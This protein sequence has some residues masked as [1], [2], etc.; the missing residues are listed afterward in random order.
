MG[1]HSIDPELLL[2]T[3]YLWD[4]ILFSGRDAFLFTSFVSHVLLNVRCLSVT[5]WLIETGTERN[6]IKHLNNFLG[7]FGG[8][9]LKRPGCLWSWK[10]YRHAANAYF[11]SLNLSNW[12]AFY[13][14]ETSESKP[15]DIAMGLQFDCTGVQNPL[16]SNKRK[17]IQYSVEEVMLIPHVML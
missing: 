14:R 11:D 13:L 5:D 1:K 9:I 12:K 15:N 6:I 3:W 10:T 8:C 7:H 16:Q 2:T 17:L 4:W